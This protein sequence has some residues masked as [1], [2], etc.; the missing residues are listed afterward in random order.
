MVPTTQVECNKKI[1]IEKLA[2]GRGSI[3]VL[4]YGVV[5]PYY[6][7]QRSKLTPRAQRG[8]LCW[9]AMGQEVQKN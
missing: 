9:G 4:C 5:K 8:S 1:Q 3:S 7:S 6:V 2:R